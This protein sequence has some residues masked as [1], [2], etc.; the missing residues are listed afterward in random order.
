MV[1]FSSRAGVI[2]EECEILNT[3]IPQKGYYILI[4]G[5]DRYWHGSRL[6]GDRQEIIN[7]RYSDFDGADKNLDDLIRHLKNPKCVERKR[8]QEVNSGANQ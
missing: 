2:E 6:V 7:F 4:H 5:I 3:G 1:I 8:S